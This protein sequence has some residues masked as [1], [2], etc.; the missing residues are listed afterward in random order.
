MAL[1]AQRIPRPVGLDMIDCTIPSGE[2]VIYANA[3]LMAIPSTVSGLIA[4]TYGKATKGQANP[5]YFPL[6]TAEFADYESVDATSAAK[7]VT[8]HLHRHVEA[9]WMVNDSVAAVT[10][11]FGLCY[12]KDDNTVSADGAGRALAGRVWKIDSTLGVLVERLPGPTGLE[13][14]APNVDIAWTAN[15]WT[16]AAI[17]SKS[18][19][20]CPTTAAAS[21]ITLPAADPVGTECYVYFD[22]TENGHNVA[23]VS[24]TGTVTL[25]T[26]TASTE[27]CAHAVK[28][29]ATAWSLVQL[30]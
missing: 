12:L 25:A 6:G 2:G 28:V 8:V 21:T 26:Q 22:G 16:P 27:G 23:I 29:S 17:E 3:E 15:A 7:K 9:Y 11:V 19:Y 14:N 30:A 10:V 1:S 24:E 18:I 13:L 4:N 20:T 5:A